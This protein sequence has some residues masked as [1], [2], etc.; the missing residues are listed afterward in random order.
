MVNNYLLGKEPV[1]FD[2]LY[3]NSDSTRMP[4]TMHN[5]YL[6]KIYLENK[7]I[8]PGGLS[9]G[10]VP[11]NLGKV[12]TP[13]F[14]LATV[15]DHIAPWKSTYVGVDIYGGPVNFCLAASDHIAGVVNA[16]DS[17]KYSHWTNSGRPKSP[18]GWLAG[19]TEHTGSWWLEWL[20]WVRR[21][22]G[23]KVPARVP[24]DSTL[25]VIEDAPG[26]YVKLRFQ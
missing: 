2:L 5:F 19:A 4:A 10:S 22:G 13:S 7:L 11:I 26:S 1:P 23:G 24:G 25:T 3:W 16:P 18:N 21:H 20:K 8:E 12:E 6:R 14:I 17:G 9:L 15:E